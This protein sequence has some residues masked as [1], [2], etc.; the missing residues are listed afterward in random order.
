MPGKG[1]MCIFFF[2]GLVFPNGGDIIAILGLQF[3]EL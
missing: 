3:P 1:F 2:F